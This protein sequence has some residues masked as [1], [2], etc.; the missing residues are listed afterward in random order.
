MVWATDVCPTSPFSWHIPWFLQEKKWMLEHPN[1][2]LSKESIS[3]HIHLSLSSLRS[4]NS[5]QHQA[6][7]L[8]AGF[9]CWKAIHRLSCATS[10]GPSWEQHLPMQCKRGGSKGRVWC[11]GPRTWT[12][13]WAQLGL[14][15]PHPPA[16]SPKHKADTKGYRSFYRPFQ[17]NYEAVYKI[18]LMHF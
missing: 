10:F 16:G 14:P 15:V 2:F 1:K 4:F 13:S 8:P 3:P 5:Y 6:L 12:W 18:Y 17:I 9:L 7:L 11:R